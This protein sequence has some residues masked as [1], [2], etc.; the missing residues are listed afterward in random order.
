[1]KMSEKV[2]KFQA[3]TTAQIIAMLETSDANWQ[4]PWVGGNVA[5]PMSLSSRKPYQGM[6]VIILW[7]KAMQRGYRCNTWGTYNAWK[8]KGHTVTKGETGTMITVF[9]SSDR[10]DATGNLIL[11]SNGSPKRVF[12]TGVKHVFNA[13]QTSAK[14]EY[15]SQLTDKKPSLAQR[16]ADI[17]AF[18]ANCGI[19][20]RDASHAFYRPSED[21]VGMPSAD[22]FIHTA[23]ST[24][25]E[26]F[27]ST[28]AHEFI[29][30]TGHGKR[31]D[32]KLASKF[33]KDPYAAEELVAEIGAAI[34]C[35]MLGVCPTVREDHAKYVKGWLSVLKSDNS[36]IFNAASLAQ[37]GVTW[38]MS[39]QPTGSKFRAKPTQNEEGEGE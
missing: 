22:L 1:M 16:D 9:N 19:E 10:K 34:L 5:M 38:L 25:T 26:N 29:H 37:K 32:R 24:A 2:E 39:Q 6:N 15:L 30:A 8:A 13:E 33:E 23:T 3:E 31:C 17:D 4:R 36:A 27:Y 35:V 12:F 20:E 7:V 18:F 14:D 28:R 11:D 21:F